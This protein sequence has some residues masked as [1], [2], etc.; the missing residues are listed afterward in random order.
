MILL[1]CAE[2]ILEKLQGVMMPYDPLRNEIRSGWRYQNIANE[3]RSLGVS[4]LHQH[5]LTMG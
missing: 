4:R 5:V 1:L 3:V 2:Q